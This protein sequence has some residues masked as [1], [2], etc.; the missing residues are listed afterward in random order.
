MKTLILPLLPVKAQPYAKAVVA[1]LGTLA[2][3][4]VL[5]F[6]DEPRVA[7]AVQVLTALGVYA[8]PNGQPAEEDAATE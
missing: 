5:Y 3:I 4:A 1:L 8:Q 6:G 7:A 2:G